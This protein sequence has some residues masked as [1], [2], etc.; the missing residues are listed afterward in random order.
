[1]IF[2]VVMMIL[3][4][5]MVCVMIQRELLASYE[6]DAV[7]TAPSV[8]LSWLEISSMALLSWAILSRRSSLVT[9]ASWSSSK[10]RGSLSF[11]FSPRSAEEIWGGQTLRQRCR[12]CIT[13]LRCKQEA[14]R[15]KNGTTYD[16]T[17]CEA[18]ATITV[19]PERSCGSVN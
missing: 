5:H 11:W 17:C 16:K 18:A 6:R 2:V 14:Q 10:K 4:L 3:L 19:G 15:A 7:C 1:M 9:S 8:S 12:H 13:H